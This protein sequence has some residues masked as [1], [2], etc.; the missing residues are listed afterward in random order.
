MFFNHAKE[1]GPLKNMTPVNTLD[2]IIE[3]NE[4]CEYVFTVTRC[5][6]FGKKGRS[7]FKKGIAEVLRCYGLKFLPTRISEKA[8]KSEKY[9]EILEKVADINFYRNWYNNKKIYY[10]IYLEHI[11]PIGSL[12]DRCQRCNSIEEIKNILSEL[13]FIII[14][15][16]EDEKL[17]RNGYKIKGRSTINEAEMVYKEKNIILKKIVNESSKAND[18]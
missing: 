10:P 3:F 8:L 7:Y 9:N 5:S 14:L 15:R 18:I 17:N 6:G 12:I 1:K 11:V 2:A 16:E 13:E 4:I